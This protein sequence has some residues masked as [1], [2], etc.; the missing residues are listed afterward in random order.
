MFC[1]VLLWS[2]VRFVRLT[3]D[4]QQPTTL[5]L[6]AECFEILGGG[7]GGG[8]GGRVLEHSRIKPYL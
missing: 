6:L 8:A 4:Q 1:A 7:A 5:A 3:R 2:R